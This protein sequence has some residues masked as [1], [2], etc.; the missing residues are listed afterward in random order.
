MPIVILLTSHVKWEG[1]FGSVVK[2]MNSGPRPPRFTSQLY[3]FLA[4]RS[5]KSALAL[6]ASV[7]S[8]V[9][10]ESFSTC[11]RVVVRVK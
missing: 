7:G 3:R 8:P 10:W 2:S 4:R 5:W 9:K 6:L 1:C 11:I